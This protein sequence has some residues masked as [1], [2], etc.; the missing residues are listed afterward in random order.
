MEAEQFSFIQEPRKFL[1][2]DSND[3]Q[4]DSKAS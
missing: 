2:I 1:P 3:H 4:T